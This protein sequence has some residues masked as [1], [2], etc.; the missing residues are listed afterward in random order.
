MLFSDA[1]VEEAIR[2]ALL[3][4]VETRARGHGRGDRH[5]TRIGLGLA[6]ECVAK[7][8]VYVGAL[9]TDLTC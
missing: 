1:D 4:Q 7:T 2:K 6:N 3:E 9:G 5:D 8:R